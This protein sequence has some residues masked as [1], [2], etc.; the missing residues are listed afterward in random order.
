MANFS[1]T[2]RSNEIFAALYNMI[3]SEE[4]YADNIKDTKATLVDMARVDGG[5]YGDQKLYYAT[6]CLQSIE[7]TNDAEANNLLKLYRPAAP[8]CQAIVFDVFR[9]IACTVDDYLS[10]RAFSTEGAFSQFNAV[11]LGWIRETKKIYD[12]TTYNTFIGTTTTTKG[13]QNIEIDVTTAV[14][15]TTGEEKARI[16]GQVIGEAVAK[17]LVDVQDISR[18]YNDY[19]FIRSYDINDLIFVWNADSVVRIEKRDLPSLYHKDI[20]DKFAEFTLP[21]R[22]FGDVNDKSKTAADASTRSLIEQDITFAGGETVAEPIQIDRGGVKMVL[23][24]GD[25]ILQNDVGHVFAGDA[26]PAKT[27]IATSDAIVYPSYQV[28]NKIL[29]KV[30]GRKSV[31]M[32]SAFEVS[33]SFYNQA[34]LTDTQRL[35][36]GHNTLEYLKNY[37]FITVKEK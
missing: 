32:M 7:W 30:M 12:S 26:I 31:P 10:K 5:L 34:S 4:V 18:E 16:E 19:G 29:F 8:K 25:T 35:I 27:V 2:L 21:G 23:A 9:F 14:G 17:L 36:W 20:I 37:P 13:K 1:G 6:D 22:Y 24:A 28:N 15:D 11:V 33:N 3:L